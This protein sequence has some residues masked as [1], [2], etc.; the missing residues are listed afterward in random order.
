MLN[1]KKVQQLKKS[2]V[3]SNRLQWYYEIAF[4]TF[5]IY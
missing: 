1:L 3:D 4:E 2:I 5:P